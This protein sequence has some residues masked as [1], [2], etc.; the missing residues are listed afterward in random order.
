MVNR[1]AIK[2]G[3][4]RRFLHFNS[5]INCKNLN[6]AL[7]KPLISLWRNLQPNCV[8]T[9]KVTA[10]LISNRDRGPH[11]GPLFFRTD[12]RV[13]M[14]RRKTRL[15]RNLVIQKMRTWRR[16]RTRA[17]C[18]GTDRAVAWAS[19][20]IMMWPV[21]RNNHHHGSVDLRIPRQFSMI[22]NP[23]ET[24][25]FLN[26]LRSVVGSPDVTEINIDHETCE[27]TDLCA[28]VLMDVM[29]MAARKHWRWTKQR[30]V[31]RGTLP[32]PEHP[33]HKLL[34][35]SGVVANVVRPSNV[36]VILTTGIHKFELVKGSKSA[37][38]SSGRK[39][40]VSS[41]LAA[42]FANCMR[43][44]GFQLKEQAKMLLTSIVSEVLDNAE[45]HG[46]ADGFWYA[47]G[48]FNPDA[49][50]AV[51]SSCH[52]VLFNFGDSLHKSLRRSPELKKSLTAMTRRQ[53]GVATTKGREHS[54]P[55][56]WTL[57]ALQEGVSRL[58]NEPGEV[59]RGGG[60]VDMIKFFDELSAGDQRLC[61]V[62]GEAYI[63]IDG[64]YRPSKDANNNTV[65]AF[66][67]GNDLNQLPDPRCV[68]ALT[69]RFP[70]T[71]ISLRFP[72]DKEHLERLTLEG[73]G[74]SDS[75]GEF[76]PLVVHYDQNND[77]QS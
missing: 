14:N 77:Y 41:G 7:D 36:P 23:N 48:Y 72:F 70:G 67:A 69:E 24:I 35:N 19:K 39:E 38:L 13:R 42:Y 25:E 49:T 18:K 57:Y 29:L 33:I 11:A 10:I 60:T 43:M 20:P 27:H 6:R 2:A 65:L 73:V 9:A 52:I 5:T 32:P 31:V 54:E 56:L 74:A 17:H 76:I 30:V 75:E 40:I 22:E 45:L 68:Y 50:N 61:I 37:P 15:K 34:V 4:R 8:R 71:L 26:T 64:T 63:L 62:S 1:L 55:T 21:Q 46:N 28:S 44:S 3:A 53:G 59:G 51:D 16:E 12:S 66:N 47:I 58:S